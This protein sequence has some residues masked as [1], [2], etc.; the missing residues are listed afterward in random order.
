MT[1]QNIGK[2][3][4]RPK[5]LRS[6][7]RVLIDW[8]IVL[9]IFFLLTQTPYGTLVQSWFQRGLLWTGVFQPDIELAEEDIVS[10]NYDIPLVTLDGDTTS[11]RDLRGKVLFINVWATWCP[12]CLAEMPFIQKL[13]DEIQDDRIEFVMVSV[14]ET[15]EIARKFI[16]A[17]DFTFP[18]YHLNGPMP[19]PYT[20]SSIPTTY[21][22]S[23]DGDVV[24]VQRGMAN[25]DSN[26][27]KKFLRGLAKDVKRSL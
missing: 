7:K 15:R 9:G 22:V 21:I 12:P 6:R 16:E 13:F 3:K 24:A 10:A 23:P 19:R 1:N 20:S 18:V 5:S 14:D 25:Y 17:R 26:R 27:F 11:L 2:E 8:A 4:K